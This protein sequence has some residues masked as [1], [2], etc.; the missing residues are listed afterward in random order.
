MTRDTQ[1]RGQIIVPSFWGANFLV[2]LSANFSPLVTDSMNFQA[3][4]LRRYRG[5]SKPYPVSVA[6]Y[7]TLLSHKNVTRVPSFWPKILHILHLASNLSVTGPPIDV[8][9]S[10]IGAFR[11]SLDSYTVQRMWPS[12]F[13]VGHSAKR[14]PK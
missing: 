8:V 4:S 11:H 12:G 3:D 9:S 10:C 13:R 1:V 5:A 14:S 6:G 2:V 7:V